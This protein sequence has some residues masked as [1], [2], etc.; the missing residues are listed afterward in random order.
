[1]FIITVVLSAFNHSFF[2]K[3][4]KTADYGSIF[5]VEK[6]KNQAIDDWHRKAWFL[7]HFC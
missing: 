2:T 7:E 1:M 5:Y 3:K 6:T 4:T